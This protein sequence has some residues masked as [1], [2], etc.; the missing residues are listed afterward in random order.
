MSI[1]S[2]IKSYQLNDFFKNCFS[3]QFSLLWWNLFLLFFISSFCISF[4]FIDLQIYNNCIIFS[5][6]LIFLWCN[7][8]F[9]S[10]SNKIFLGGFLPL[11]NRYRPFGTT[12]YEHTR[13]HV[14]N[15][16]SFFI[17]FSPLNYCIFMTIL[18]WLFYPREMLCV[19]YDNKIFN[20]VCL[21][22]AL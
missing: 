19:I 9:R 17:L 13:V 18:F 10:S 14:K 7:L 5:Y 6:Q 3:I 8:F 2:Y 15:H 20:D 1:R 22:K 21:N 4:H 16:F 12:T 11:H